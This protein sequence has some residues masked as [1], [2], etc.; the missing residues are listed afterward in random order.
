MALVEIDPLP[1]SVALST[2]RNT[3]DLC[4]AE[5]ALQITS[6]EQMVVLSKEHGYVALTGAASFLLMGHLS[7]AVGKARDK[8]N[9][10][11]P[12][13]YS[14]DPETGHK[15]NCIQRAHQNT[16]EVVPLFLY[17]LSVGGIQHPRLASALGMIWIVS[18]VLYAQGYSTGKPEKRRRG[19][20]GML[21]LLGLFICTLNTGRTLLGWGPG[22]RFML[23]FNSR[24]WLSGVQD[25]LGPSIELHYLRGRRKCGKDEDVFPVREVTAG[26]DLKPSSSLSPAVQW[27]DLTAIQTQLQQQTQAIETL[28]QSLRLLERERNAQHRQIQTLQEEQKRLLD[29]L[30]E[31]ERDVERRALSPGADRRTEQWK[32]EMDRELSSLRAQI[33]R[34]TTLGN[35]EESFSSKLRREEVEQLRREVDIL[36]NK[37]MRQEEDTF[38]LQS[39]ARETRRQYERSSKTLESFTDSQRAH[40]FE[41]A[42]MVSQYQHTQQEVRDLRVTVSE[43]KD[44]VRGLVLRDS[45]LPTPA[46]VPHKPVVTVKT[47]AERRVSSVSEDDFSPTPSLAEISSDE[48]DASWL[49]EPELQT[50]RRRQRVRLNSD[51]SGSDISE[52]G[53]GLESNLDNDA[54]G[55]DRVSDSPPDLSLSDL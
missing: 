43:L 44:E 37:L 29:K 10:P 33:N 5:S 19:S 35:Q 45:L 13:M 12:T 50:R 51:L 48:L 47:R 14:D 15:F 25:E 18:R 55:V 36:K 22:V 20:F 54:E 30:E 34:A 21:A 17:H 16:V 49:E 8:Y 32:R 52:A 38:Q 27:S 46:P 31:R 6:T 2:S 11:Y 7:Y 4:P 28:T 26:V 42:R 53:S 40:S 23:V 39:E 24:S 1:I 41:L 3:S 9:V